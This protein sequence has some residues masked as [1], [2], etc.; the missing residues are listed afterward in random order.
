M[1][2]YLVAILKEN[3]MKEIILDTLLD[4]LKLLPFLFVAF[5]IMEYIEHKFSKKSKNKIAKAGKFGPFIGSILGA[6]P[7]CGF[8]VMATNLYAT[9]IITVG[10]LISIYL[11]T[12][13]EMLPI[14]ISEGAKA[15]VIFKILIIKIIVGM[16]CGFFIDL[17]LRNKNKEKDYEIKDFCLEHHCDCNHSI[18]KSSVKHTLN[19]LL[20]IVIITFLLNAGIHYLGE[21][22][23]GKLFLKNS[24]FSPF[25]SSLVGLIPNCG[26]S[27]V[28]TE[29]YLNGV[30]SFASCTAGLL[31][32]SGVALLV[33]FKVNKDKKKNLKI[34]FTLYL[35]GAL[36][37]LLIELL[38]MFI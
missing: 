12:S 36:T 29:L 14:L 9:R 25:I 13:D 1:C 34:I 38:E 4:A 5:L 24:F 22:N 23:I 31:T 17:I 30:I 33:L 11:S 16:V 19:I 15:N 37:G 6:V 8:S 7:Q 27:V 32:G 18:L 20:F 35:I 3:T 2:Y 28:L 26:A 10:T 21:D